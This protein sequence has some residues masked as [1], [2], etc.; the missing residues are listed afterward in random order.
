MLGLEYG[1]KQ[2]DLMRYII[3]CREGSTSL[4]ADVDLYTRVYSD[5]L[6]SFSEEPPLVPPSVCFV[7]KK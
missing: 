4:H 3:G 6:G 5:V 2:R 1:L 7:C